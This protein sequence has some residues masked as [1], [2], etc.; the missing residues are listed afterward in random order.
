MG[1]AKITAYYDD[2]VKRACDAT[3]LRKAFVLRSYSIDP[4][5]YWTALRWLKFFAVWGRGAL[6]ARLAVPADRPDED[7]APAGAPAWASRT[8]AQK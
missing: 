5:P 4:R 2:P 6:R 8:P 3:S 7:G 1:E